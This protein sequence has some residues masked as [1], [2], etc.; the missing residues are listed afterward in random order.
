MPM[1]DRRTLLFA[2]LFFLAC[3]STS[4]DAP[5]AD[6]RGELRGFGAFDGGRLALADGVIYLRNEEGIR[7]VS[8]TGEMRQVVDGSYRACPWTN[9]WK[10]GREE[11][12]DVTVGYAAGRA[13]VHQSLCGLWSVLLDDPSKATP[14]LRVAN[15]DDSNPNG[16]WGD[17]TPAQVSATARMAA[18]PDADGLLVCVRSGRSGLDELQLWSAS[19]DGTPREMLSRLEAGAC[20]EILRDDEGAYL[21]TSTGLFRWDRAS[22][23]ATRIGPG[24]ATG[25]RAT[26]AHLFFVDHDGAITRMGRDGTALTR[27]D[28][29]STPDVFTSFVVDERN[30]H[31][32]TQ[33]KIVRLPHD[34]SP[35]QALF[36]HATYPD[37]L[38][39]PMNGLVQVGDSVWFVLREPE[40]SRGEPAS[41]QYLARLPR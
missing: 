10:P 4:H 22:R 24:D 25:L 18:V 41:K 27:I 8:G 3:G 28:V 38:L 1:L 17:G 31:A 29:E 23:S 37:L 19:L 7:A 13:Y 32:I 33:S 6:I 36:D 9:A 40:P 5:A 21:A 16:T 34:G 30:L 35:A 26:A 15:A 39:A 11:R 14:I 20:N 2:S 12:A